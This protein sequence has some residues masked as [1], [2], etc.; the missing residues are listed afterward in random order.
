[1]RKFRFLVV[2]A[3]A[4]M[5]VF[6]ASAPVYAISLEDELARLI[7]AHPQILAGRER[8]LAAGEGVNSATAAFLPTVSLSSDTGVENVDS[9]G[10][11]ASPPIKSIQRDQLTLTVTQN[12]FDG[13]RKDFTRREAQ[14][15]KVVAQVTAEATVQNLLPS[16]AE[17]YIE[18]LSQIYLLDLARINEEATLQQVD[19]EERKLAGGSG[20]AV[21]VALASSRLQLAQERRVVIQ[22][23]FEI[24]SIRYAQVFGGRPVAQD[25]EVPNLPLHALPE[26]LDDALQYA[27]SRNSAIANA[28]R[29]IEIARARQRVVR[30]DYLPRVD[31]VGRAQY[32]DDV[33]AT[34]GT[35][36]DWSVLL[37][38]SWDLFSGFS[39][40]AN[41]AQAAFSY[42]A[43]LFDRQFAGSRVRE[44]VRLAWVAL[45]TGCQRVFLLRSAV[46]IANRVQD[47]RVRLRAAGRATDIDVLDSQSQSI[48]TQIN[49]VSGLSDGAKSVYRLLF[50]MGQLDITTI[51]EAKDRANESLILPVN[52]LV[53]CDPAR[54]DPFELRL[55]T[56]KVLKASLTGP[57][58]PSEPAE[59]G[60]GKTKP[61]SEDAAEPDESDEPGEIDESDRSD[62]PDE[63]AVKAPAPP[64]GDSDIER[65]V[66][67]IIRE[68]DARD[69]T[70]SSPAP[71]AARAPADAEQPS[72]LPL[73]QI[74]VKRAALPAAPSVPAEPK[75]APKIELPAPAEPADE[76]AKFAPS[77][78]IEAAPPASR[79]AP[80][81]PTEQTAKTVPTAP[82]KA[83][84][85]PRA[86]AKPAAK[87]PKLRTQ[88][89]EVLRNL[90]DFADPD[91]GE[92]VFAEDDE[93]SSKRP[94]P[95]ADQSTQE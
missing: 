16:G 84:T 77:K 20:T 71:Q 40:R 35:R 62:E 8:I 49:L 4:W 44:Q 10:T 65:E 53:R 66:D 34:K 11:R 86:A 3:A 1:M 2:A 46:D 88:A 33:D 45:K 92:P 70:S 87:P 94:A 72:V 12:I 75:A 32:R 73:P 50:A 21:D 85:P 52:P 80:T 78:P 74:A 28:D 61:A 24:A 23:D 13:E 91:E 15:N 58:S 41:S 14:I 9:P 93:L 64:V 95:N 19:L 48:N 68:E 76:T 6:L 22:N 26:T 57:S 55:D 69:A 59:Q 17:A 5:P 43:S 30:A 83:V 51:T 90:F 47:S 56:V 82:T 60:P 27:L 39:R 42:S 31:I 63:P 67:E 81:K 79:S 7:R 18:M 36:R 29:Q 54:N 38:A 89:L 37:Q 25:L